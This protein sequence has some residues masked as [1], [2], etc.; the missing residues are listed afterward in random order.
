[1]RLEFPE[2]AREITGL[3]GY[4]ER[5]CRAGVVAGATWLASNPDVFDPDAIAEAIYKAE[6]TADDGQRLKLRHE[7]SG[8]QMGVVMYHVREIALRGWKRYCDEISRPL[9]P[10]NSAADVEADDHVSHSAA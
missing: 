7:L 10:Q 6:V 2:M 5:C 9:F 8:A 1:M 4:Y 3:G